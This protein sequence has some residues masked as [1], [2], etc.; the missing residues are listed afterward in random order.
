M[1]IPK[2]FAIAPSWAFRSRS[3][4]FVFFFLGATIFACQA[5]ASAQGRIALVIGNSHYQELGTLNNANADATSIAEL[6]K[7]IGYRTTLIQEASEQGLRKA[8]R[9]FA[10]ESIDSS[11]AIV[12]Y[13]GHGAQVSGENFLLPVDMD[14]P[15]Q[16]GDIQ[17]T[18]L[19]VDDLVNALHAR[20]K[21]VFLDACRDNPALFKNLIHGRGSPPIGL[22]PARESNVSPG[23][24]GGGVF[25]AYATDSDSVALDGSGA[26]SPF[27]Q[28]LLEHL[29]EPRSID[30]MFSIV[31]RE[32]M[33]SSN[34]K[35]RPYKYASLDEIICI[36]A[37]CGLKESATA[38]VQN[39]IDQNEKQ[40]LLASNDS[41]RG[42]VNADRHPSFSRHDPAQLGT[43][44]ALDAEHPE[45]TLID[46]GK[47]E[48]GSRRLWAKMASIKR[49]EDR[50]TIELRN[51]YAR[52][53][54]DFPN[55]EKLAPAY[56]QHVDVF[57]CEATEP[58][59]ANVDITILNSANKTVYRHVFGPAEVVTIAADIAP[60]SDL[61]ATRN[62]L[63]DMTLARPLVSRDE[64]KNL[65]F[66]PLATAADGKSDFYYK[67]MPPTRANEGRAVLVNVFNEDLELA[68]LL[69]AFSSL[70]EKV[71]IRYIVSDTRFVCNEM[72][73]TSLRFDLY[74]SAQNLVNVSTPSGKQEI[75]NETS[76]VANL[77]RLVCNKK[78][79]Q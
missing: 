5:G 4:V 10:A 50:V 54:D 65:S 33:K 56:T 71:F 17:L 2:S 78:D 25:I 68:K 39:P 42:I 55:S 61:D 52:D 13:A 9:A 31:T 49:Y 75:T 12:Y 45:W 3:R 34:N 7:G 26:H 59:F 8:V 19:K 44:V 30:D 63:C 72:S 35:Q 40:A 51:D 77:R 37:T 38:I 43:E 41:T 69:P 23:A 47:P 16:E 27:A 53:T 28:A 70:Q 66:A 76:P 79:M 18:G 11:I 48:N 36:P 32:V 74:D 22:A 60:K 29:R 46:I 20:V 21:V 24:Q 1:R 14:I 62:A 57:D 6:L 64:L 58:K 15:R 67:K 73:Y